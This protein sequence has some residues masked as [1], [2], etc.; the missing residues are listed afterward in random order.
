MISESYDDEIREGIYPNNGQLRPPAGQE[1]NTA[2]KPMRISGHSND[3]VE[4][5]AGIAVVETSAETPEPP[6]NVVA[7][8]HQERTFP[9]I[10]DAHLMV[11]GDV[12]DNERPENYFNDSPFSSGEVGS[13]FDSDIVGTSPDRSDGGD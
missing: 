5:P 1:P 3:D 9:T 4:Y 11:V 8:P 2:L 12:E 7:S 13:S 6:V 10:S